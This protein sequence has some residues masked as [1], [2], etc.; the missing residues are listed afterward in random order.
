MSADEHLSPSQF[1]LYHGTQERNLA[2]I[3]EKGITRGMAG[4]RFK[5]AEGFGSHVIEMSVGDEDVVQVHGNNRGKGIFILNH[6]SPDKIV[7]VHKGQQPVFALR[8]EE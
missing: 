6:I 5:D 2:G 1:T 7:G 8:D 4:S 3:R